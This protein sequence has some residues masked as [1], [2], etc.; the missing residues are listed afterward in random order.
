[1]EKK[2]VLLVVPKHPKTKSKNF[3]KCLPVGL[4]KIGAWLKDQG[5]NVKL[6]EGHLLPEFTPDEIYITTMFTYWQRM[7]W[8][9]VA[10]YKSW[11]PKA[12]VI[13]GGIYATLLPTHALQSGADEVIKGVIS[14]AEEYA[15]DYSLLPEEL[16]YLIIHCSRG[17]IRK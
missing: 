17:C 10:Y 9:A 12:K 7:A 14:E 16:D 6:V 2:N 15:P 13:L 4:L 11:Y 1:M 5:H 3:D 8:E